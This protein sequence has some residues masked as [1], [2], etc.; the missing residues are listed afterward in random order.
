LPEREAKTVVVIPTYNEYENIGRLVPEILAAG[1]SIEVLVVDDGSPDGTGAVVRGLAEKNPRVHLLERPGKMGLGS[2]YVQGFRRALDLGASFV[3]QMDADF[4]HDPKYIADLLAIMDVADV[5]I[6]SRY[7]RGV[8]VINWPISRLILSYGANVYTRIVTGMPIRDATG[9]FKCMKREALEA[10]RF[11]TAHSD[12][13]SFQ[14]EMNFRFW[15]RGFRLREI[16]IVFVD[17]HSGT[18]KM[19]KKIVWEAIWMVWRLRVADL[20]RG[21]G[22]A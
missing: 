10:I 5:A 16:P 4:S 20:L 15:T 6:G 21:K 1:P 7:V 3:V 11:E 19:S 2:A 9:G 17:R 8:N 22:K 18:S 13:Y 14:I 12:G